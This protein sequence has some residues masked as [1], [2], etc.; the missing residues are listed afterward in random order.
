MGGTISVFLG[1]CYPPTAIQCVSEMFPGR[2]QYSPNDIGDLSGKVVLI[3][4]ANSGIG[5][6]CARELA[7]HG[8]TVYVATRSEQKGKA[9]VDNIN[10]E[11][12]KRSEP[13]GGRAAF[14]QLDLAD[15]NSV[16][17]AAEQFMQM[18]G[19]LDVLLNSGGIMMPNAGSTPSGIELH[20]ATNVLGHYA[21][22]RLLLPVLKK[23]VPLSQD[24]VVRVLNVVSVGVAFAPKGG[25]HFDN[26]AHSSPL[27]FGIY[28][29]SKL[30]NCVF[31][32]ELARRYKDDGI[33]SLS[34]NPGNVSTPI[35]THD[36]SLFSMNRMV[37]KYPAEW[38]ALTP[39]YAA[40]SPEV[41][42]RDSGGWIAPWAHKSKHVRK[43]ATDPVQ[44][45]RLWDWCEE[46]MAE[47]GVSIPK[48][49]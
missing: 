41:T 9:A 35:W 46:K 21:L 29:Q 5:F 45:A 6:E 10:S 37:V 48:D 40:T 19:R 26:L 27:T 2:P 20:F 36:K 17:R 39:L 43:E 3:T 4:G 33:L 22:T 30:G 38:G 24:G 34:V 28:G 42:M 13:L 23:T 11:I 31:A 14:L 47:A 8:A 12:A 7:G 15:L 49:A 32:S 25:F 18:E 16:Q 44:G 1:L